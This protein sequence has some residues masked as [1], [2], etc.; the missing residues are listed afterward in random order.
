MNSQKAE[1][2]LN[3][4]KDYIE[5]EHMS[6]SVRD[7]R[8]GL[9]IK[10]TSTIHRY[11][12]ALE[13]EGKIHMHSKKNR[14]IV[15]NERMISG[16]PLVTPETVTEPERAVEYI[17]Y[18][19]AQPCTEPLFAVRAGKDIPE[20]GILHGDILIAKRFVSFTENDIFLYLDY[21]QQ[22]AVTSTAIPE[23][24]FGTLISL[25]RNFNRKEETT[26]D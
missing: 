7:I 16:I 26:D 15:I 12:H 4:V 18:T 9:G 3:F 2:I 11:L 14:S 10:S 5:R 20:V 24:A 8:E 1:N 6:P 19:P 23:T 13:T 25:I 17:A 22:I 21:D